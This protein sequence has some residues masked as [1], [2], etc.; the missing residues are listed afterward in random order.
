MWEPV[1]LLQRLEPQDTP[2][3]LRPEGERDTKASFLPAF[4]LSR[5]PHQYPQ[6]T[7]PNQNQNGKEGWGKCAESSSL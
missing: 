7:E 2:L 3:P 4:R 6:L 1:T 5:P